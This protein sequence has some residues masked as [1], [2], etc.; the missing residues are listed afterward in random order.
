MSFLKLILKNPFR[1]KSRALLSIVGIG[2]GIM[3][4]VSLGAISEGL[5]S[6][7]EDSL[8]VGGTDFI[9][10]P[11]NMVSKD[12]TPAKINASYVED[13]K[14]FKGVE[15]TVVTSM[16]Y[17]FTGGDYFTLTYILGIEPDKLN[18][19]KITITEGRVFKNNKSEA[20]IGKIYSK[21]E[22]KTIGDT[23]T[24][25]DAE[26][27]ITGIFETGSRDMD[28]EIITSLD[29]VKYISKSDDVQNIYVKL[30]KGYDVEEVKK[31]FDREFKDEN[32][33]AVSSVEDS[34]MLTQQLDMIDG[35]SWAISL[36]A[37][38]VGGIGIVNTMIM[39]IFERI[40]EIGVLKSVGWS[41]RRILLMIMGES[42]VLTFVSAIVGSIVAII[43]T[44]LLM[45]YL[46]P[47]S[48]FTVKYTFE[49]FAKAFI[50]ALIVGLVGG[51]YPAYKASK[52]PPTEAL[53]YE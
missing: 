44:Q 6:S 15:E 9:V 32:L 17:V 48:L 26:F 24:F 19:F 11:V 8:T 27:K 30:E 25:D 46:G 53:R 39:S 43:G 28:N 51:F 23:V 41:K 35:A 2:I 7:S 31:D 4:I 20:I 3:L 37:I 13:V 50:I 45:L 1:V 49:L 33:T 21:N 52:M 36:L 10:F 16:H 5:K 40:R 34:K 14:N 42:I 18:Y 29:K 38:V 47:D 12:G 22:N